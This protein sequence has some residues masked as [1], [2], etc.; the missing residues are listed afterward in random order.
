MATKKKTKKRVLTKK[1]VPGKRDKK[2]KVSNTYEVKAHRYGVTFNT[3]SPA[4]YDSPE[5][6]AREIDQYFEYIKGE[7]GEQEITQGKKK[8]KVKVW[9]REPEPTSITGLTLYLG[10]AT[11][12]SLDDYC[13]KGP[14]FAEI[15]K[16]GKLRVA[17]RYE[18]NLSGDKPTGSIFALKNMGWSDANFFADPD[19]NATVIGF[20]YIVPPKPKDNEE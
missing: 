15:I 17:N 18:R 7:Q 11:L 4:F 14:K 2:K 9:I 8:V 16:R 13:K 12:Q 5:E 19:G 20:Q 10:F 6:M 1:R 3:G